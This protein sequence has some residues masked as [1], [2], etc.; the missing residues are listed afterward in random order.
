MFKRLREWWANRP[1]HCGHI[2][3]VHTGYSGP[4]SIGQWHW[5]ECIAG[6]ASWGHE[7]WGGCRCREYRRRWRRAR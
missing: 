1:C 2:K 6:A 7:R 3:R 5:G 4:N